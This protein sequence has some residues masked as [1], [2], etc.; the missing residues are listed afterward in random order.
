MSGPD[1]LR[2]IACA[3]PEVDEAAHFEAVAFRVGGK[4]F[5][6]VKPMGEVTVSLSPED[7]HILCEAHGSSFSP[8][9]GYWGRKGWTRLDLPTLDES[10][11]EQVLR[12]AWS[13][14]APRKA[15]GKTA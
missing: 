11:L 12:A 9:A 8:V 15:R 10:L 6:T 5:A 2:K 14:A 3:L 7:Q 13:K 1:D 4:I